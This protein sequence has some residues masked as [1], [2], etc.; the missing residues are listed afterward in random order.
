MHTSSSSDSDLSPRERFLLLMWIMQHP[1]ALL[2]SPCPPVVHARPTTCWGS[3]PR[4]SART[5][6]GGECRRR[7][8]GLRRGHGARSCSGSCGRPS[9]RWRWNTRASPLPATTQQSSATSQQPCARYAQRAPAPPTKRPPGERAAQEFAHG[10]LGVEAAA[11]PLFYHWV[12]P[13]IASCARR[14]ALRRHPMSCVISN[15]GCRTGSGTSLLMHSSHN[16]LMS[17]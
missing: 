12:S 8:R 6:M 7:H 3:T 9:R 17:L 5:T 1:A 13:V 2:G 16:T 14:N 4:G 11:T 10:R 15:S